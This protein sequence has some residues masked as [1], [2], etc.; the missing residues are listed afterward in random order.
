[1]NHDPTPTTTSTVG[2]LLSDLRDETTTLL[3][4]EIALAKAEINEKAAHVGKKTLELANGGALAYAGLI[5]LL[6]G[7]A[8]LA[9]RLLVAMGLAPQVAVWLGPVLIGLI[10][11]LIG[12]SMVMKAT[13][14]AVRS[15][16]DS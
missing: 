8:L 15:P 5:V 10:V 2:A 12:M 3:R 16:I 1:M 11:A 4:Q 14:C 7:I 6:I 13:V 9:S